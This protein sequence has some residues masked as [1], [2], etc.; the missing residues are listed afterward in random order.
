MTEISPEDRKRYEESF[1]KYDEERQKYKAAWEFLIPRFL[2]DYKWYQQLSA[3][4]GWIPLVKKLVEDLDALVREH[5][6]VPPSEA[7]GLMQCKEKLGGLRFYTSIQAKSEKVDL[8]DLMR[9]RISK[10]E[11]DSFEVCERCGNPGELRSVGGWL[12]SVCQ[13]CYDAWVKNRCQDEIRTH[14]ENATKEDDLIDDIE[15]ERR[16]IPRRHS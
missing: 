11:H 9:Q 10:A 5:T 2:P 14:K 15:R 4:T 8:W 13:P 1:R 16:G 6:D 12:D 3:G 7:W